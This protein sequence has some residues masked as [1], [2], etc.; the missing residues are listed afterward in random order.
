MVKLEYI[1]IAFFTSVVIYAQ[2]LDDDCE[3]WRKQMKTI[4]SSED[5]FKLNNLMIHKVNAICKAEIYMASAHMY[6][7]LGKKDSALYSYDKSIEL[8]KKENAEE[9]LSGGYTGKAYLWIEEYNDEKESLKWLEK[10]KRILDK[11]ENSRIW[12]SY[13]ISNIK[14]A[15][16]KSDY[17]LALKYNDSFISTLN[18]VNNKQGIAS[19]YMQKGLLYFNLSNYQKAAENLLYAIEL[20]EKENNNL[21][22]ENMYFHLGHS[23]LKWGEY[24]TAEKYFRKSIPISKAKSDTNILLSSY[25]KLIR[26]YQ[27]LGE[28]EKALSI[29]DSTFTLSKKKNNEIKIAE[30]LIEKGRLFYKNF[31]RYTKAE[32]YFKEAYDIAIRNDVALTL[33]ESIEG[34]MDIYINQKD[35]EKIKPYI[36]VFVDV[37][38]R[39]SIMAYEQQMHKIFSEYY[40]QTNNSFLAIK[41]LRKYYSIKDSISN[42]QVQTKVVDLEKKYDTKKKELAIVTLNQQKKEQEQIAKQAK[43]QQYLYLLVAIFLLLLLG[44]GAWAFRKLKKQQE[45]LISVNQVKNRLFSIIAHDLRG[46]IIPFQRSG[47]ILKYHIEKGNNEKTIDLSRALEQNSESLSNMLDNLLNWSLEQMNGYKMTPQTISIKKELTEIITSYKQQAIYKNTNIEL[48]YGKDFSV[49]F[50]KGAFH[51]IFRNLIGNALKY[52]EEGNIRIEFKN[53]NEEFLCSVIDTGVGMSSEQLENIFNLEEKK[54]TIGTQGEKGTGLGLNL[55]YRFIKMNEGNI[56]VSSEKRI[57][58]R[59][60]LNLPI[61]NYKF[62]KK[63]DSKALSA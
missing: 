27:E 8:A 4:S 63:T 38:E 44:I 15:V 21:D 56:S 30:V 59:F 34:L 51:V 52:T 7:Q 10:A 13:Y 54:S 3:S 39:I 48:K 29:I 1:F 43:A 22:I 17:H 33:Y 28:D 55:I 45:E 40:E 42:Q 11:N 16:K 9:I 61:R 47:K 5:L 58:T 49:N 62:Y 35:F 19:R 53:E 18:R 25:S 37:T 36:K 23:Y 20:K 32:K 41:H 46:M 2:N 24:K 57:G 31:D 14:I 26:C 12:G 6:Q 50:D 60:D